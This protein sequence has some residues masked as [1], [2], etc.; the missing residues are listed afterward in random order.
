[1]KTVVI[2]AAASQFGMFTDLSLR[3]L[4]NGAITAALADSG[5]RP[6]QVELV[7]VGNAAAGLITG[8][9]MIRAHTTLAGS[10]LMGVPTVAVENACASGSSAFHLAHMAIQSGQHACVVVVGAE[11]MS[12]HDR[13]LAG[14]ALATATDL[15]A[16]EFEDDGS[17]KPRPV[18]M[19]IYAANARAYMA[20]SGATAE[21]FAAVIVKNRKNGSLNPIAQI[22][23]TITIEEVLEAREIV[24]P[25]TRPMCA[26]I[27]DGVAALV[28]CS[29]TFAKKY[30]HSG[31]TVRAALIGAG[32]P[33]RAG[34]LVTMTSSK[35]FEASGVAPADIDLVELHDAAAPAELM[36]A[37]E[38][39]LVGAGD[40]PLLIREG[41]SAIN[42]RLPINPSGGLTARG[43]PIGATGAAQIVELVDQLR[44]RAGAR[45]VARA[46]LGLAENAGGS[47]FGGG[48]ACT[49][50]I[51]E[52]Q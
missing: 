3:Q 42:G 14:K 19:E 12:A 41:A 5:V 32:G 9:E 51:L 10:P 7:V 31:P 50:T 27:G 28:L 30:G 35:A 34:K 24:S 46:R 26:G 13:T 17:G 20:R 43:H 45:Q 4:A 8:Q 25:L 36:V 11:K 29:D 49:I 47:I 22:R 18:F 52:A 15:E 40:G 39:G 6:D 44:G 48:A 33:G 38:L 1:M 16:G 37:E 2:G 21:D 23:D